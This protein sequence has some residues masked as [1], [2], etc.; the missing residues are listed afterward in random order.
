MEG[1]DITIPAN[2]RYSD[3]LTAGAKLLYGE[4]EFFCKRDGYC[5]KRNIYF[6]ELY[7]TNLHTIS[8]WIKSLHKNQFVKCRIKQKYVR[9]IFLQG[10]D[11][12][13]IRGLMKNLQGAD[14]K[15][16]DNTT[17]YMR[18][19]IE[20][21]HANDFEVETKQWTDDKG[22]KHSESSIDYGEEEN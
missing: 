20:D 13:T 21:A 16:T 4:I 6:A 18:E 15:S 12:K 17:Y 1:Y 10:V 9:A 22:Q 11:E 14:E 2:V 8:R 7:K 19:H 3:K 5:L